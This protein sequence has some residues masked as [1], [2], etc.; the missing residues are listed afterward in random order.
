MSKNKALNLL[1]CF[2]SDTEEKGGPRKERCEFS[3]LG[4]KTRRFGHLLA[5]KGTT[6]RPGWQADGDGVGGLGREDHRI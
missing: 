3:R 2:P 6:G 5:V 1:H 4:E